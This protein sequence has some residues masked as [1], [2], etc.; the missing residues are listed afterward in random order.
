MLKNFC[1]KFMWKTWAGTFGQKKFGWRILAV[2]FDKK[3][4]VKKIWEQ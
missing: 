2:Y 4:L 3:F 1:D